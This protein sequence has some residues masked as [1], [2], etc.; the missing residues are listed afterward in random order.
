M[1]SN[2][3]TDFKDH[4]HFTFNWKEKD[5]ES[6]FHYYGARYYWS[7]LLTG[8]LSV[9]PM[10]DKYPGISPYAY[11]AWN[12]VKLVDPD[13]NEPWYKLISGYDRSNTPKAPTAARKNPVTG[14]V[15]PHH[16]IDMASAKG[17][18]INSAAAGKI[19][20]AGVK[21]GYGNTVVVDHGGGFYTLYAHM[22]TISVKAGDKVM[23][24]AQLGEVGNSGIGTG[25]HL[26][27]EYIKTDNAV[28][29][30]GGNKNACRFNPMAVDD[31]QNIIDGKE[32][33]NVE[34]LDGHIE[35]I[36][37]IVNINRTFYFNPMPKPKTSEILQENR[38]PIVKTVGDILK[39]VGL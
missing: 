36:G 27:V 12:P 18:R 1:I 22:N 13:G 38:M 6:G 32:S 20:F 8:W 15:R 35:N 34:F 37:S 4:H 7:E 19:L 21:N 24:G 25:P 5:S 28:N 23:N 31:L 10:M 9:D 26:H 30:F 17:A 29:I 2:Y 39:I 16:G 14:G 3:M 11:C 33:Q